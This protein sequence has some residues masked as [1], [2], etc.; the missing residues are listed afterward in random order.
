LGTALSKPS[1]ISRSRSDIPANAASGIVSG[2]AGIDG[3]SIRRIKGV[4][5]SGRCA[6]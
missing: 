4:D 2:D 3:E 1:Q 5:N 6:N